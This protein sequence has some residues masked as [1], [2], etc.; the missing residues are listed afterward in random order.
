MRQSGQELRSIRLVR[1]ETSDEGTFGELFVGSTRFVT[2]ELPW[3][4]NERNKSCIPAGRYLLRRVDSPKFGPTWEITN[5]PGRTHIL[6]H[7]ANYF[8]DESK[9]LRSDVD[10]CVGLGMIYGE[11]NGQR[12]V[13]NSRSAVDQFEA[14]LGPHPVELE[15][16]D[17]FSSQLELAV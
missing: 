1:T 7:A 16:V 10:G 2:G 11:L 6:F 13:L 8:G 17:Q 15:I 12:A 9:G 3:R 5:V 14:L 4:N